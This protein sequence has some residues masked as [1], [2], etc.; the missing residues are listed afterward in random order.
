MYLIIPS[1]TEY[2]EEKNGEKYLIINSTDE[3]E[4]VWSGIKSEIKTINGGKELFYKKSYARIGVNSDDDL[5]LN[6]P[7]KFPTLAIII[8]CIFQEGEKLFPQIYLDDCLCEL[9]V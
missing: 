5:P 6:K 2:F 3:Y 1:A 4:E 9:C 7:L 8:R